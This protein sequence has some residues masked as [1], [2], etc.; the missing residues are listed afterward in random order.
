MSAS[1]SSS[2]PRSSSETLVCFDWGGVVLQICRSWEEGCDRA[3]LAVHE[4]DLREEARRARGHLAM[5]YQLG[6]ISCE[7][8]VE[9][10]AK[11]T[12]DRLTPE[13]V[14]RLHDAWLIA[15]Y[16][17]MHQVVDRLHAMDGVCTALLSNTNAGHWRRHLPGAD[18]TPAD[19]PT[20]GGLRHRLGSHQL[21]L[22][23]PDLAIYRALERAT[24]FAPG[25]IVFFDDL[26]ENILAAQGAGWR[27]HQIDHTGNTAAQIS[28]FLDREGIRL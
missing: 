9:G 12:N 4:D 5:Q 11:T 7:A 19:F 15:E 6:Q 14:T 21:A 18:G 23:K 28:E 17:G 8:F 1:S 24:G 2:Q 16:P 22:A 25:Q 13:E 27:A 10:I 20:V 26:A 3:G